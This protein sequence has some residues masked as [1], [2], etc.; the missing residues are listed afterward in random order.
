M[1]ENK[2]LQITTNKIERKNQALREFLM[3][4]KGASELVNIRLNK[5]ASSHSQYDLVATPSEQDSYS[6]KPASFQI[7][8]LN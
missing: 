8:H 6:S 5:K 2:D 4:N 3:L 7:K 1:R